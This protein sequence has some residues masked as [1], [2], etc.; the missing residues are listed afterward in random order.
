MPR[1]RISDGARRRAPESRIPADPSLVA[2][3]AQTACL[4]ELAAPKP[5]NVRKGHDLPGLTYADLFLSAIAIGPAFRR[6]AGGPVGRLILE[7]VRA[8]RRQVGTNTNLGIV[9]LLAPLARAA[10]DA[11]PAPF[12]TRLRRVLRRLT[13]R[14][15]RDAYRAIRLAEPG[16]LGR[17][18]AQDVNRPPTV[19]LRRC[20]ALAARRDAIAREYATGFSTTLSCSLPSLIRLRSRRVPLR[21]AIAQVFLE[22][23][24]ERPDTLIARRHGAA[25]ARAVRRDARQVLSAGGFLSARGRTMATALDR[26]LRSAAPPLNPGATA[27]LTTATLFLWLLRSSSPK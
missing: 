1:R 9:L 6:H 15:A 16:G 2:A 10:A 23:L 3:A 8:T 20:M 18:S 21:R 13:V 25:A 26:R 17:V 12:A 22:L 19:T 27:D 7:A 5:G 24:A 14:D 11:G 4:L